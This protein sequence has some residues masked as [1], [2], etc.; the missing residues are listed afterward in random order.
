MPMDASLLAI[1]LVPG[2][3]I[4]Q[5]Y[6]RCLQGNEGRTNRLRRSQ[7]DLSG[8]SKI[9]FALLPWRLSFLCWSAPGLGHAI[10]MY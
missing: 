3:G 5:W 2:A 9:A 6:Q 7:L 1:L 8:A 4:R 10:S